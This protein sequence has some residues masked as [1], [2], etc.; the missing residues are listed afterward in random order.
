MQWPLETRS[1]AGSPASPAGGPVAAVGPSLAS[2]RAL[3]TGIALPCQA[4]RAGSGSAK[5]PPPDIGEQANVKR[6]GHGNV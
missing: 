4:L 2:G 3:C 1:P 6:L 5:F